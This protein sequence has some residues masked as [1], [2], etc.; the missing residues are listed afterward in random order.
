M[1]LSCIFWILFLFLCSS[2]LPIKMPSS[3]LHVGI[4]HEYISYI[5]IIFLPPT[6]ILAH[7]SL[8]LSLCLSKLT[9][10]ATFWKFILIAACAHSSIY[11]KSDC[12]KFHNS[13]F[14]RVQ[15][16]KW[17][18]IL[19]Y[20]NTALLLSVHSVFFLYHIFHSVYF[21]LSHVLFSSTFFFRRENS[22]STYYITTAKH[23]LKVRAWVSNPLHFATRLPARLGKNIHTVFLLNN[24]LIKFNKDS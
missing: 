16:N 12:Q 9:I 14:F 8:Y 11:K 1:I 20:S 17:D 15:M 19:F 10:L 4:I 24:H 2:Q 23:I 3:K 22:P 7:C 5:N 21:Y 18:L 13:F 6:P